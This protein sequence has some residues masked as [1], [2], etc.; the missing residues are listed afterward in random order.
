VRYS[1][2]LLQSVTKNLGEL[3]PI[4]RFGLVSDTWAATVAGLTPLAEFIR[5][6]RLF[7]GETDLSV[8]RALLAGFNYVDMI[9]S[10][11]QRPALAAAVRD[12]L[13]EAAA[14]LGWVAKKE[15]DELTRQL[16]GT[17]IGT[18]GT[19]GE[20]MGVQSRAAELY[21]EW[22]RDPSLADRDLVPPLINI[23]AHAGDA[24]RYQDFKKNFKSARTPQEEQRY[25]FSLANFRT[26]ELLRQTMEMTL[27][28]E[29]RTQNAP[30]L[31]HSLLYNPVSRYQG[32]DFIRRNWD[33]MVQKFPDSALPRMC[34]AVAGLLDRQDEVNAF[35]EQHKPRLG[36]KII[37]Q[38]LERLAVAVAFRR[39]EGANLESALKS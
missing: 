36:S 29:V 10:D 5:M 39:R 38:H 27:S 12:I 20:D 18:L 9:V 22:S 30:F 37:D 2:D 4:E 21:A 8:W 6:A 35:F 3:K 11:A 28:G 32:W 24:G 17:V 23:L 14:R 16:R 25:L 31:M 33:A 19:L 7:R 13:S 34:E 15:E 26:P 1:P